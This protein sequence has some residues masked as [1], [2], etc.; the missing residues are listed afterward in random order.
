MARKTATMGKKLKFTAGRFHVRAERGPDDE[1]RFYWRYVEYRNGAAHNATLGWFTRD[2]AE[3]QMAAKVV[4]REDIVTKRPAMGA[5]PSTIGALMECWV[6]AEE[7]RGD[8]K[9][10]TKKVTWHYARKVTD[11]LAPI[12]LV[13]VS[14]AVLEHYRDTRVA[15][16]AATNCV[17]AEIGILRRAWEWGRERQYCPDVGLRRPLLKVRSKRPKLT[18]TLEQAELILAQ[19]DQGRWPFLAVLLLTQTGMRMG[20]IA[21][22]RWSDLDARNRVL[23][24]PV[25][26][27]TG[28]RQVPISDETTS[29]LLL[30]RGGARPERHILGVAANTARTSLSQRYLPLAC[31]AAGVPTFI[32]HAFR[33]LAVSE[34]YD[35]G[36]DP[37]INSALLGHSAQTAARYY[38]NVSLAKKQRAA[39]VAGLLSFAK[40]V[41]ALPVASDTVGVPDA[42]AAANPH[43]ATC[44]LA[45]KAV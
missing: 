7:K 20:E 15:T 32:P 19:L 39:A 16:G 5:L 30:R 17:R 2:V 44:T 21:E 31:E 24:T 3:E 34:L 41:I 45:E 25:S 29:L 28:A 23:T 37:A 18:P 13:D 22:L 35:S 27:K 12:R 9:D 10:Q 43:N 14:F 1:G 40:N 4:A 36:S 6:F 11:V 38:R 42:A 33:R 8:I 26:S